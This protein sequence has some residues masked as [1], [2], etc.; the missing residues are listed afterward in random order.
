MSKNRVQIWFD[1]PNAETRVWLP[2]NPSTISISSPFGSNSVEVVRLGEI[3]FPGNR[4]LKTISFDSHFPNQVHE[5]FHE[6]YAPPEPEEFVRIFENWRDSKKPARLTIT[7]TSINL[8]VTVDNFEYEIE[9]AGSGGATYYSLSLKEY[10]HV[11]VREQKLAKPKP[12]PKKKKRPPAP[13]PKP[14][15]TYTVKKGDTLWAIAKRNYGKG[16]QWTK[17]YNNAKN[18]K[19]IGKNPNLIYP[20]QKLVIP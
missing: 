20:G 7:G 18:K 1:I 3:T 6:Y 15:K 11:E 4:G 5:T 2:V 12:K 19:T 17:I 9:R 14:P 13:K 10:R 8:E 16:T